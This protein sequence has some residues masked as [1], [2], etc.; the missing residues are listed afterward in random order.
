M[1]RIF[2]IVVSSY[3][4]I[5]SSGVRGRCLSLYLTELCG[6]LLLQSALVLNCHNDQVDGGGVLWQGKYF[7]W[8]DGI[9][10]VVSSEP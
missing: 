6:L 1:G 3:D 5:K 7:S 4:T 8:E 2:F 10:N 9:Q